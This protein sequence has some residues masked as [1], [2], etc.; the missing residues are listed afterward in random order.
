MYKERLSSKVLHTSVCFYLYLKEFNRI[1]FFLE[2]LLQKLL[3]P[4]F[5]IFLTVLLSGKKNEQHASE[6]LCGIN[7]I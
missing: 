5:L 1:F 3:I 6:T 7:A 2:D 4:I